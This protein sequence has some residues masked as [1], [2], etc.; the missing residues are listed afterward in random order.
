MNN[1]S[2][3]DIA[4]VSCGTLS[5]ELN[6]LKKEGF[7]DTSHLFYTTPGLHEDIHELETQ[8]IH[9]LRP[10]TIATWSPRVGPVVTNFCCATSSCP[11]MSRFA[12]TKTV[13]P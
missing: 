5:L 1:L 10:S 4:I 7:L 3:A 11:S 2:F 6:Y 13:L 9:S 8:L 12:T